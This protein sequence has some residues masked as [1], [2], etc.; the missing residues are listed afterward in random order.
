METLNKN[1]RI[2]KHIGFGIFIIVIGMILLLDNL[3]LNF[4]HWIFSWST[5]LLAFGTW[6]GFRKDFK[7][8]GWVVMVI[9]GGIFTLSNI[10]AFGMSTVPGALALVGVGLYL[11]LKPAKREWIKSKS[12]ETE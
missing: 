8:G 10:I 11:V 6:I 2:N 12:F 1:N 7:A 3:G 9:V 4:P 5:L